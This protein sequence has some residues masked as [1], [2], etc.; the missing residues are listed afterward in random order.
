[1]EVIMSQKS[2]SPDRGLTS[3]AA[4]AQDKLF[5]GLKR[6]ETWPPRHFSVPG[7]E[8]SQ[9]LV[10]LAPGASAPRHFHPGEELTHVRPHFACDFSCRGSRLCRS[11]RY[12]LGNFNDPRDGAI[13]EAGTCTRS[14][15]NQ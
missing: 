11:R 15:S 14:K 8:I 7:R 9:S 1:M 12:E 10:E 3:P 5:E 4:E 2:Q 13:T 6:T